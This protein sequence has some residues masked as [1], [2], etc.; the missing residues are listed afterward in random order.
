MF[1]ILS[2]EPERNNNYDLNSNKNWYDPTDHEENE[3]IGYN[4]YNNGLDPLPPYEP[5]ETD[6]YVEG[7]SRQ[8]SDSHSSNST[9]HT[10]TGSTTGISVWTVYIIVGSIAGGILLA[11]LVA[12]AIALCCQKEEEQQYKSTSV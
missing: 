6:D 11:G 3:N 9:A 2:D 1:L 12:I 8:D 10:V 4:P 5:N 7:D